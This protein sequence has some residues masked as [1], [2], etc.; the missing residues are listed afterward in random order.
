MDS[1]TRYVYSSLEIC[2][3]GLFTR[4]T[5]DSVG[6]MLPFT[7]SVQHCSLAKTKST[8]SMISVRHYPS[9]PFHIH[10]S[11]CSCETR[12]DIHSLNSISHPQVTAIILSNTVHRATLTVKGNVGAIRETTLITSGTLVSNA[13]TVSSK[14][15]PVLFLI[16]TY[17]CTLLVCLNIIVSNRQP[18]A[19]LLSVISFGII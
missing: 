19:S 12:P 4:N 6:E 14:L 5:C 2:S 1:T 16:L 11:I 18:I 10:I 17:S 8:S 3:D 7:V 15:L 9:F 13:T